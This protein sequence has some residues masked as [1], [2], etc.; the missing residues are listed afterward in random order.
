MMNNIYRCNVA[1]GGDI[2]HV[3]IKDGVTVPE[4]A[5]L[6]YIHSGGVTNICFT[7]KQDYDSGTERTRLTSRYGDKVENV[8]GVYGD[9][10]LEI[11][12]LNLPPSILEPGAEPIGKFPKGGTKKAK[13]QVTKHMEIEEEVA[14]DEP[15][16]AV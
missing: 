12:S 3:V 5:I 15:V 7:G 2:R 11:S 13:K 10:P 16:E 14:E 9:L 8:F 1:L 4:I 6:R